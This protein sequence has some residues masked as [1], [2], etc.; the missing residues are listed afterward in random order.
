MATTIKLIIHIEDIDS[1][2]V[3]D[4]F[5]GDYTD[6]VLFSIKEYHTSYLTVEGSEVNVDVMTNHSGIV[7]IDKPTSR[8]VLNSYNAGNYLIPGTYPII[9]NGHVF[10]FRVIPQNQTQEV[11]EE[12]LREIEDKFQ[13]LMFSSDIGR[14]SLSLRDLK[15]IKQFNLYCN[16][17]Q[18]IVNRILHITPTENITLQKV[19]VRG[20][21]S[22][23]PR[24]KKIISPT[25]DNAENQLLLRDM[26][27][28]IRDIDKRFVV[29]DTIDQKM[30]LSIVTM[31]FEVDDKSSRCLGASRNCS[32]E[33]LAHTQKRVAFLQREVERLSKELANLERVRVHLSSCRKAL[34]TTVTQLDSSVKDVHHPVSR[35]PIYLSVHND[36]AELYAA[37]PSRKLMFKVKN[38]ETLFE[39]YSLI[40]VLKSLN[41]LGFKATNSY[42]EILNILFTD[43]Y[44]L[45]NGTMGIEIVYDKDTSEIPNGKASGLFNVNSKHTRPDIVLNLFKKGKYQ[46]S[47]I[48]E[49]KYRN[50]LYLYNDNFQTPTE[51]TILDYKQLA[52]ADSEH[53]MLF[54]TVSKIILLYPIQ[55]NKVVPKKSLI[56][57]VCSFY[58]VSIGDTDISFMVKEISSFIGN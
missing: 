31:N 24:G 53:N 5:N 41:E 27:L 9:V 15:D 47:L 2:I 44:T 11:Y 56:N 55:A 22:T 38:S 10:Y 52:Y 51:K 42:P 43:S 25:L 46:R 54:N 21:R 34:V 14:H 39:Y 12:M 36:A 57:Q 50:A 26:K 16:Q 7:S 58:P 28:L 23:D 49:A 45:T 19:R 17:L 29:L 6:D 48:L 30:Q 37:K 8:I 35:N 18:S 3:V 1:E 20:D 40:T 13:S 33:W 32:P 4:P